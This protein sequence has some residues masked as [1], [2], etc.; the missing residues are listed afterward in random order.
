[1]LQ[2]LM[3]QK[4]GK[5]MRI[6]EI[7]RLARASLKGNWG[8]AIL[9]TFITFMITTIL[10]TI[11]EVPLS[12][13]VEAWMQQD[14]VS[15]LASMV[16]LLISLLL[17]PF[18][19]AVYWFYLELYRNENPDIGRTFTVYTSGKLSLKLIGITILVGIFTFL[20]SLLLII[21]GI[22]KGLAYS[23]TFF[24]LKDN[25]NY[26]P[27]VAIKESRKRM[28]GL[29]WK[30][31]LL[32]LSFIGWG[33]LSLITFGIGLLWL[34]PYISNSLAAFYQELIFIQNESDEEI[35]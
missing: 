21:P 10:P 29:K 8:N 19:I 20:W 13:G 15:P 31:F 1:M 27:L 32:Y 28:K 7:K 14:E 9:L 2:F 6:S 12:G 26:G 25:P 22:I 16:S 18:S 24:L 11:V 4:G 17:I 35:V 3:D 23:Q 33:L 30:L 5:H 34:V